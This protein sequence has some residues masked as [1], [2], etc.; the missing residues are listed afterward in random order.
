MRANCAKIAEMNINYERFQTCALGSACRS[1][2]DKFGLWLVQVNSG[3]YS[4]RVGWWLKG[5]KTKTNSDWQHSD[6][7]NLRD[8]Y[9]AIVGA[10]PPEWFFWPCWR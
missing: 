3:P 5:S 1:W 9:L 4:A 7:R 8:H 10:D 6:D 2:A